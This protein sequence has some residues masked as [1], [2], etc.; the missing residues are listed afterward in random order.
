MKQIR[1]IGGIWK[2]SV[3]PVLERSGLRP[4]PNRARETL[5]NWLGQNLNHLTCIDLFA[6]S[7]ALSFEAAS[8]GAA[9]VT[10]IDNDLLTVKQLRHNQQRLQANNLTI[11]HGDAF[12]MV[13]SSFKETFDI[14][15]LDPPFQ[16][17]RLPEAIA[18][19]TKIVN[20][21]GLIYAEMPYSFEQSPDLTQILA[22]NGN[23]YC[24]RHARSG[25]VHYHL[26]KKC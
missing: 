15:F 18:L 10:L 4:T 16:L 11:I 25:M 9:H 1:I 26:F 23:W 12:K 5:F 17:N 3:L 24:H 6:G 2:K 22:D 8:R 14:V 20:P 21:T 19:A 7:G 13:S